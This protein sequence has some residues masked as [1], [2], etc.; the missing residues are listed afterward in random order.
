MGTQ[1]NRCCYNNGH[2]QWLHHLLFQFVLQKHK[3]IFVLEDC[4]VLGS[5]SPLPAFMT[6]LA[7]LQRI[8]MIHAELV[9]NKG[10]HT[11][12]F[13]IDQAPRMWDY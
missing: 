6:F 2:K 10:P 3:G 8:C 12:C 4:P 11:Q 7:S 5:C 13:P 9:I 1:D